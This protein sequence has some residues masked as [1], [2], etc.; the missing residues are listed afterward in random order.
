MM[1][2][3]SLAVVALS[4]T[5]MMDQSI[6]AIAA[7]LLLIFCLPVPMLARKDLWIES[8]STVQ[9]AKQGGKNQV[10]KDN[11]DKK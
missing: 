3:G 7:V 1:T 9:N 11:N 5:G 10:K 2:A 4:L 8:T 6:S